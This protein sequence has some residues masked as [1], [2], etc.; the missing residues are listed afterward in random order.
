MAFPSFIAL[1][2]AGRIFESPAAR[3]ILLATGV[4]LS[5]IWFYNWAES[6]GEQAIRSEVVETT[7]AELRRQVEV[8]NT[9]LERASAQAAQSAELNL[10]LERQVYEIIQNIDTEAGSNV[11]VSSAVADSLRGLQ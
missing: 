7:D 2:W 8:L 5:V 1:G 4:V 6:K 3:K 9:A 10:K 11:C